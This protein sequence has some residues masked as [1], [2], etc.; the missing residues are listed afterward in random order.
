MQITVFDHSKVLI[1]TGSQMILTTPYFSVWSN[2]AYSCLAPPAK[3]RGELRDVNLV[4]ISHNHLDHTDRQFLYVCRDDV[5]VLT[6]SWAKWV[7]KL[8]GRGKSFQ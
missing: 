6:P 7:T 1:E 4:L 3:I 5:A 2:I 8:Y